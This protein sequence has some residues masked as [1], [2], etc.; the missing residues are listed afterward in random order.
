MWKHT[1]ESC[2]M[3]QSRRVQYVNM[4]ICVNMWQCKSYRTCIHVM[5][6]DQKS[7]K[8][9]ETEKEREKR[10][11]KKEREEQKER[12]KIA[13]RKERENTCKPKRGTVRTRATDRPFFKNSLDGQKN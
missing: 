1:P 6:K 2:S 12:H 10:K 9:I 5:E 3:P 4:W 13:E 8:K 11:R 7:E